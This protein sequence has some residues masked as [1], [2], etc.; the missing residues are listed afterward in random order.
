MKH[1]LLQEAEA[2]QEQLVSWRR[3]LHQIPETGT[4]LPQTVTFIKNQLDAIGIEYKIHENCSCITAELG[5]GEPCIMLRSDMDGLPI[6]E[7]SGETFASENGC[8]HACGH[9]LHAT[10]LLGAARLLK[11]H[12]AEIEGTVKLL[13][14]SGEETFNGAR[15]AI[16]AGVMENPKVD[17]AFAMHVGSTLSHN[18][19]IYSE[20]PMSSVYG[21]KIQYTGKGTHGSTPEQGIDPLIAGAKLCIALQ[22]L[23]AR[24]ISAKKEAVL[25]I[26]KFQAGSASNVIPET[27]VIEGTLRTFEPEIR[28]QLI[29]RITE[30]AEALAKAYRVKMELTVLSDVPPVKDDPAMDKEAVASIQELDDT[31]KVLPLY[32]VMGSEDFAFFSEKVPSSYFCI[33]AGVEDKTKWVPHHNPKIVFNEKALALGA[34]V[35]AKVAMDWIKN[36]KEN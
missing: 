10:V 27:A 28:E 21:F 31:T 12:E 18:V 4:H 26:G 24:E 8:M 33:G 34:A 36:H 6:K 15:A 7:E 11:E 13:F 23:I 25:T 3:G 14:Q 22:E 5:N 35:Y 1:Q 32:H 16:E 20:Y 30:M 29:V 17:V 2:M 19:I 9:D